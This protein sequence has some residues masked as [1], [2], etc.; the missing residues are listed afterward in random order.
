MSL[1]PRPLQLCCS[2][3]T[4]DEETTTTSVANHSH[5]CV[6]LLPST[7]LI[8]SE[9]KGVLRKCEVLRVGEEGKEKK[10]GELRER[11][12]NHRRVKTDSVICGMFSAVPKCSVTTCLTG[13]YFIIFQ[14][15]GVSMSESSSH[16]PRFQREPQFPGEFPGVRCSLYLCFVNEKASGLIVERCCTSPLHR[17]R[18]HK[19][20]IINN[21]DI[22]AQHKPKP[23]PHPSITKV[24]LQLQYNL[25][26]H[27]ETIRCIL[28]SLPW[29]WVST[30]DSAL[31][32]QWTRTRRCRCRRCL[33][34]MPFIPWPWPDPLL[35]I[36]FNLF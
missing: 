6:M 16:L 24:F 22:V 10:E 14:K 11:R 27:H 4:K 33:P 35:T 7:L 34:S 13:I 5:C 15:K 32:L 3:S 19:H 9:R 25:W 18:E 31:Y 36:C 26:N 28:V 12:P 23:K 1:P 8:N 30:A 21:I 2:R 29:A 17:K 20:N